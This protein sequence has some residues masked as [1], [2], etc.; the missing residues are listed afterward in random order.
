MLRVQPELMAALEAFMAD[1]LAP[2]TSKP[3]AVRQLVG[4][5]LIALGYLPFEEDEE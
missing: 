2:G 4:D 3:E 1:T 5:Q